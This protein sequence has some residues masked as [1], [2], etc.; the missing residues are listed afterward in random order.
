MIKKKIEKILK[1]KIII[2]KLKIYNESKKHNTTPNLKN[3]HFKIIIVSD[4][5]FKIKL[6]DRHRKIHLLLSKYIY[7]HTIKSLSIHTYTISEWNNNKNIHLL[8][9]SICINKTHLT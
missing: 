8:K 4:D 2:H 1:T 9:S 7:E 6:I 3:T 5:F